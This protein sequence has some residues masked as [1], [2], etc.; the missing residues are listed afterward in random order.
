VGAGLYA[1][2]M[3]SEIEC[4]FVL[5]ELPAELADRPGV[6]ISQ[7]YLSNGEGAE[8]RLR[9]A[10]ER[11]LLTVKT[12]SGEVREEVEVELA[13]ELFEALWPL[14]EGRRIVKRRLLEPLDRELVAEV[15]V[16]A[17]R[18]AGLLVAEVEFG[19]ERQA[20]GFEPPAWLGREVTGD[21][22]YAN[23]A[24]AM[25]DAPPA[26]QPPQPRSRSFQLQR[27]EE[28]GPGL[29]RIAEGR[30]ARAVEALAQGSEKDA[31]GAIH[32]ARK[33][34]KKLR[35]VLRLARGRLGEELYRRENERYRDAARLLSGSR[36]AEVKVATLTALEQRFGKEMPSAS[37]GGWRRQLARERD[38]ATAAGTDAAGI[39]AATAAIAAGRE[40]IAGWPLG[41]D[42]WKLVGPGLERGYRR[43]RRAMAATAADPDP[44]LVHAWRK[45]VKDLWYQLR[46]LRKAWP[47]LL[48]PTVERADRLADL[49]GD[50]H[51]LTV[52][53][54]DLAT[55]EEVGSVALMARL[56]ERRQEELL[57][58]ALALGARLYAEKPRAFRRRIHAYWSAWR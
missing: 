48:E 16:Y 45:R 52:L 57:A 15:D 12:G 51:D 53:A 10:G 29:M 3:S 22:R 13:G 28:V 56:I 46:L 42:S 40:E 44:E 41:G 32:S 18:L 31:A 49:L 20:R 33:D 17:E 58:E 8:I 19:S 47:E 50:H 1:A 35:S 5:A 54:E 38:E 26:A 23:R 36:D 4:K 27:E 14:T 43:G 7:G 9:R 30:A 24:L 55:R 11:T 21:P 39:E 6:Q 37:A 2:A 25:S 34:L